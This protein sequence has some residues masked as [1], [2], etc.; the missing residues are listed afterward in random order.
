MNDRNY[1]EKLTRQGIWPPKGRVLVIYDK[2]GLTELAESI[3]KISIFYLTKKG[4]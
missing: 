4:A 3:L 1:F 2:N